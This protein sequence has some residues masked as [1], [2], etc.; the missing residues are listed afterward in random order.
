MVSVNQRDKINAFPDSAVD[1]RPAAACPPVYSSTVVEKLGS[2]YLAARQPVLSACQRF[3]RQTNQLCHFRRN[4]T[5][6]WREF[7]YLQLCGFR[8]WCRWRYAGRCR[9]V[10]RALVCAS[11]VTALTAFGVAASAI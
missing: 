6:L 8:R 3:R 11:I 7:Q 10:Q 4:K 2:R 5:L 9:T 1:Y